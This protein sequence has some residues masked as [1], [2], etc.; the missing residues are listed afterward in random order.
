MCKSMSQN[1]VYSGY[2]RGRVPPIQKN[3]PETLGKFRVHNQHRKIA[4]ITI[5]L[6]QERTKKNPPGSSPCTPSKVDNKAGYGRKRAVLPSSNYHRTSCDKI[7]GAP[8]GY[9]KSTN[10]ITLP[11]RLPLS[12]IGKHHKRPDMVGRADKYMEQFPNDAETMD[13]NAPVSAT[14]DDSGTGWGI[15]SDIVTLGRTWGSRMRL[16]SSNYKEFYTLLHALRLHS[17]YWKNQ[18]AR[19]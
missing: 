2:I 3:Y 19:M 8:D 12:I 10:Q 11:V 13:P 15:T 9:L 5:H 18:E 16:E 1:V 6:T 4:K 7:L 17:T 14:T